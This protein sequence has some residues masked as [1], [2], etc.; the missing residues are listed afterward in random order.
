MA[1]KRLLVVDDDIEF[2]EFV[3]KVGLE[4]GYAV[5]IVSNG[6]ITSK[7]GPEGKS[8]ALTWDADVNMTGGGRCKAH[9]DLAHKLLI[10]KMFSCEINKIK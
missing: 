6:N 4:L 3:R 5:G 7:T 9:S 2:G 8:L 1:D 10:R